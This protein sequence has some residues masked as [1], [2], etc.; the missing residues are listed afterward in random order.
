MEFVKGQLCLEC[1]EADG[2]ALWAAHT[3]RDG[4]SVIDDTQ[5]LEVILRQCY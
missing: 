5:S 3:G 2:S 4:G 1:Q